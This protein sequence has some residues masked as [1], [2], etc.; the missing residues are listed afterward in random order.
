MMPDDADV[1]PDLIP[2]TLS[3]AYGAIGK[4]Q[5][6]CRNQDKKLDELDRT[7]DKLSAELDKALDQIADLRRIDA[8]QTAVQ[9]FVKYLIGI[10]L[11][12]AAIGATIITS[13]GNKPW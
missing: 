7:N 4:L 5:V 12:A 3:E 6:T 9:R 10:A 1:P 2:R 11:G 13:K 8:A